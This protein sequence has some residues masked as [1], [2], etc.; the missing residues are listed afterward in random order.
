MQA[1]DIDP[2][3][4][5][6]LKRFSPPVTGYGYVYSPTYQAEA[7]VTRHNPKDTLPMSHHL[8]QT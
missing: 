1:V 5:I 6:K 8:I 7:I 3:H 2:S 4:K